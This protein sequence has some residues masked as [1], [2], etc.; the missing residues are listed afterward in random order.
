MM[1]K[2]NIFTVMTLIGLLGFQMNAITQEKTIVP[3]GKLVFHALPY[4]S[5]A[6]EPYI[7][8]QTMEI[9]YGKHHKA[10]YDNFMNS[11]KGTDLESLDIR[12][13]FRNISKHPAAVRNNGGGYYNHMLYWENMTGTGSV[14]P[15]GKLSE[16]IIR[17]FGSIDEFRKQFSDAAKSRFGSGWA[18]LCLDENGNLFITSTP[19]QDNPLMDISE[20][21]GEPLLTL[22][23]WEHAYYLKYQNKRADY[24]Q[25]FWNVV[26]W[27][28]VA[29]RYE[30]AIQ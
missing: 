3:A 25:A 16:A 23:V 30:R 17:S 27:K 19:N 5:D 28:E 29:G 11:I 6:L 21:R 10:Y 15:T 18:W 9:H 12:D 26:N 4:S 7:D 22:D 14:L 24:I 2:R 8:K 1:Y 13:I 20:K